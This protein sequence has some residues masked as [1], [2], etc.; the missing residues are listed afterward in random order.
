M[1]NHTQFN[2]PDGNTTDGSD[3][4]RIL[5]AQQPRLIQLAVKFYF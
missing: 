5:R 3:F 2:N 4:G 1:F